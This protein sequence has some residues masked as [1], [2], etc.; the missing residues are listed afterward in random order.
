MARGSKSKMKSKEESFA[1]W[2]VETIT[3]SAKSFI[4]ALLGNVERGD[5]MDQMVVWALLIVGLIFTVPKYLRSEMLVISI[6]IAIFIVTYSH[7]KREVK[8]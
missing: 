5:I 3:D 1:V 8:T 2:L 6:P 7:W 4:N